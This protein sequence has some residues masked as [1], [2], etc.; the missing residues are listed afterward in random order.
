LKDERYWR[1]NDAKFR[2]VSQNVTFEQFEDIVKA[3]HLKPL[4]KKDRSPSG[5]SKSSIWNSISLA[6]KKCNQDS[7]QA[8]FN[9]DPCKA[10]ERR[11]YVKNID[12]FHSIWRDLE[13]E[14]RIN[15]VSELGEEII[16]RIFQSEIPPELLGEML[17]TFLAFRPCIRD[18]AAVIK[19]LGAVTTSKRFNLSVQFLSSFDR[20]AGSQLVEKLLTSL[21]GR[22]QDLAELGVTEF[23]IHRIADK[24][25]VS[26]KYTVN[27]PVC[28]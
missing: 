15:F 19:T 16:A 1:E 12:E 25:N 13:I 11:S 28:K 8:N 18:I 10:L 17:H 9:S 27:G 23:V 24:L 21:Q 14:E 2:A 20:S 3:S 22:Q 26:T 6:S 4:D 7:Q 5:K